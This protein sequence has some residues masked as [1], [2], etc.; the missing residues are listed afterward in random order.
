MSVYRGDIV[1]KH[2]AEGFINLLYLSMTDTRVINTLDSLGL[3]QPVMDEKYY[4]DLDVTVDNGLIFF[5]FREIE[6]VSENGTLSLAGISIKGSPEIKLPF[7]IEAEDS[8]PEVKEKIQRDADFMNRILKQKKVWALKRN[9]SRDY[10][11][12]IT[13]SDRA[14]INIGSLTISV[15]DED[16]SNLGAIVENEV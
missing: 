3:D 8:Y 5:V 16:N 7:T 13:F 1:K 4:E 12:S 2:D 14:L 11:L 9:D 10:A 6:G 15:K